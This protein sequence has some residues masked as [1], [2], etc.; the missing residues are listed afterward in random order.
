MQRAAKLHKRKGGGSLTL[1]LVLPGFPATGRTKKKP[2][3]TKYQHLSPE[4]KGKLEAALR[5]RADETS[6]SG[7]ETLRTEVQ[8][9][10][11][12]QKFLSYDVLPKSLI[13]E[14]FTK[15][16][17]KGKY[18]KPTYFQGREMLLVL[19]SASSCPTLCLFEASNLQRLML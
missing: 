11:L 10:I 14:S 5:D 19:N 4:L 1:L 3:L 18:K 17:S 9:R 6:I 8:K 13:I 2:D 12:S 15:L 7:S 16:V